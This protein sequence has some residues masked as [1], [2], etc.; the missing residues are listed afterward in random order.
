MIGAALLGLAAGDHIST[1]IPFIV[2]ALAAFAHSGPFP[3]WTLH[4]VNVACKRDAA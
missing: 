3:E 1:L 4:C 2:C